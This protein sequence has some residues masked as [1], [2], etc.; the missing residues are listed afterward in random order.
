[1]IRRNFLKLFATLFALPVLSQRISSAPAPTKAKAV[2]VDAL[3]E[4]LHRDKD[5]RIVVWFGCLFASKERTEWT[6]LGSG[7]SMMVLAKSEDRQALADHVSA[8]FRG[9]VS[10]SPASQW[11]PRGWP[12]GG[13]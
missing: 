6:A 7:W 10:V 3:E 11:M 1:M 13:Q 9:N 8:K 4:A 5:G 2:V 12:I